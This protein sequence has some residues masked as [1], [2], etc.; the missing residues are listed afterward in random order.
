MHYDLLAKIKN[1]QRA[2]KENLQTPLSAF[3]MAVAQVLVRHGFLKEAEARAAG[4]KQILDIKLKYDR[5]GQP[6][7]TDFK[8][9]SKP[10][11]RLYIGYRELKPVRQGYG[12]SILSTPGGI[13]SNREARKQKVGGEYL[14]EIW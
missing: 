9:M 3:N 1:A 6:A 5:D 14:F 11:R 12:V 13:V 8:I 2:R 10:S 4:K 7:M